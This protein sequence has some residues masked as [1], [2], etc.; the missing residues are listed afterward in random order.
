M[1]SLLFCP[2]ERFILGIRPFFKSTPVIRIYIC[3]ELKDNR[4]DSVSDRL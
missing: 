1:V 3:N 2:L 4:S